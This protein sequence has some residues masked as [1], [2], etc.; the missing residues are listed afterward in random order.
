MVRILKVEELEEQRREL[1][2][3]S[4]MYRQTMKL[5]V[6]NIKYSAALY[7]RRFSLVRTSSRLLG[8]AVP[9]VSYLFFRHPAHAAKTGKGLLAGLA[10]GVKTLGML[11]PL[12]R[13]FQSPKREGAKWRNFFHPS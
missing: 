13:A 5:Q 9:L 12:L 8:L 1:L 3:R 6:A 2:A 10:S 7:K 4:E 11:R